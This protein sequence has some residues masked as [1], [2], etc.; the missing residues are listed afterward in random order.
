MSKER[1]NNLLVAGISL[2]LLLQLLQY[3]F[4]FSTER[5][6]Q[7]AVTLEQDVNFSIAGWK[8]EDYQ[9][10]KEKYLN[11][12]FGFRN[13][14][15]RLNN[16]LYFSL[17]NIAKAKGVV[18]GKDG[19]LFEETYINDYTGASFVG[20]QR[21][22]DV[23]RRLTAIDSIFKKENKMLAV[24]LTPGKATFY[25]E[26][27][28]DHFN[29]VNDSTN[30]KRYREAFL[31]SGIHFIDFNS[32]F[33]SLKGTTLFPIYPKTGIHWSDYGAVLAMDSLNNYLGAVRDYDPV[34]IYWTEYN[35]NDS[36][37]DID[38]DIEDGMNIL[39][40]IQKPRYR[41][42]LLQYDDYG[43]RRPKVMVVGDSFYR[44]IFFRGISDKVF[45]SPGFGYYF[46]EMHS[47]F[48]GGVNDIASIDVKGLLDKYEVVILMVSEATLL[49]FPYDFDKIVYGLYCTDLSD[50]EVFKIRVQQMENNIR[51]SPEWLK[52]VTDK[53]KSNNKTVE[54]MIH[55]D[56]LYMI[57]QQVN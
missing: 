9:S 51:N 18:V 28:P 43:S 29:R 23:V 50:P 13:Y 25:P 33:L 56:A 27:I 49:N 48:I 14:L 10:G 16:Q 12:A 11:Q 22:N 24:V 20:Q 47:P 39:F 7:G 46:K 15:V 34:E 36:I 40:D 52:S 55:I 21:I 31:S 1:T 30:Y 54:E 38:A 6:L 35:Q 32:Y 57:Q 19:Y 44:N 3:S 17:F 26:Y 41:Y 45:D 8:N 2:V 53:A 5:P 37:S 42:P 4:K